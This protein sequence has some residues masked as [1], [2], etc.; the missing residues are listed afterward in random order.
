MT[1]TNKPINER[2]FK[3][4]ELPEELQK[5]FL[6]LLSTGGQIVVPAEIR[7]GKATSPDFTIPAGANIEA[8][9]IAIHYPVEEA[10]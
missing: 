10:N 9:L 1:E 6:G 4:I 2:S 7:N 8:K 5:S 3:R